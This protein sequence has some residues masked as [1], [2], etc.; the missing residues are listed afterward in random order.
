M[1]RMAGISC[2]RMVLLLLA[3][4]LCIGCLGDAGVWAFTWHD[5]NCDGQ[6]DGGEVPL[7]GVSICSVQR[8]DSPEASP[9]Q[10]FID[11]AQ[12]DSEGRWWTW[13]AGGGCE[14]IFVLVQTPDGFEPTT[15][16]V[17]NDCVAEFG[18][19]QEGTCPDLSV[20]TP[21]RLAS[22]Q[23]NRTLG[24]ALFWAVGLVL[25]VAAYRKHRSESRS[26]ESSRDD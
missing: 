16:T 1:R 18:F 24:W 14:S 3:A 15:N 21:A 10:C 4:S 26:A 17:S 20:V 2:Q 6:Q 11:G 13:V 9:D 23:R 8:L 5:V 12:T 7:A 19:A 22:Q 25:F